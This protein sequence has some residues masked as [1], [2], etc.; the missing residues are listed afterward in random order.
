MK[1]WGGR[2]REAE[3]RL[4][5]DFNSSFPFDKR[6][7]EEDISGSMAHVSMLGRQG[8][9]PEN[10]ALLIHRTLEEIAEDIREGKL[11]LSGEAQD[12]EDIHTF[13]EA[14]LTKRIGDV[15][16]KLHTGRS[17]ND[18]VAVDMR[19]FARKTAGEVAQALHEMADALK[20]KG[21]SANVLMPGYTHLQRA[22][23]VTF[24]Y[25]LDAYRQMFLRD[26]KRIR[27]TL[28]L[29][30]ENPLGCGA[31]AGTTHEL[32]RQI[33]TELLE[34]DRPVENFLDG[35][36]DRDYLI[37]L[38][39]DFSL[40]MMHLSRLSEELI[41]WSS[42]EFRFVSMDDAY[43][44]GS[45]IMPQKK[46]PDACELVRGKT[47]RVYG[48]LMGLLT[49]MKGLPLAYDKDMQ[50]D[51]QGFFDALDTVM[52]CLSIMKEVVLTLKVNEET[53]KES[54]RRGFLNATEVADY[55]VSRGIPFRDAHGIVGRIVIECEDRKIAIED[56]SVEELKKFSPVFDE[57]IY[58][59]L[60]YNNILQKG[61]K[62]EIRS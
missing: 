44:T 58:E 24:R 46:N 35:V 23:V 52:A 45:S 61:I 32:D 38:L 26:E 16:K 25:Y 59:Y 57:E 18:Q 50:E 17:R 62:K 9:I 47:G 49:V 12:A 54:V 11:I 13:V 7:W 36:S 37:E 6:L 51:K 48:S 34:F 33:T 8:I 14:E 31:L 4:M 41:L 53:M 30:N 29:M 10:E 19:L 5:E 20:Q 1:L 22:Q 39:S 60:D 28:D 27:N 42:Q 56:L 3:N 2:F 21:E 43:S 55:L 40:I 15:G